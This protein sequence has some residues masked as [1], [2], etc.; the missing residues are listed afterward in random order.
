MNEQLVE[1]RSY[2]GPGYRPLVDFQT[3]RVALLRFVDDLRPEN[4]RQ[5]QRHDETDEVFVLMEGRCILFIGEG[6]P[7]RRVHALDLQPKK[8][9]NVRKGVWHTHTLSQDANVLIVENCDTSLEN[10]PFTDL[11]PTQKEEI[12]AETN[13]LW[14]L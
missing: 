11:T 8:I 12:V 13:R 9:Y 2:E 10:S 3:W 4:L 1:I 14:N 6:E 7:V 5:M